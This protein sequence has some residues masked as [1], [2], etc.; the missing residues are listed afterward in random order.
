VTRSV[1]LGNAV[2]VIVHLAT[3]QSIVALVANTGEDTTRSWNPGTTVICH[4]PPTAMRVLPVNTL[5]TAVI[6]LAAAT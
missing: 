5:A 4:L 1:Y 6:E 2:R 3:G